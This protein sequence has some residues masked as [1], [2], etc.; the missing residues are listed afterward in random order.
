MN[1]KLAI[2]Y[3]LG[4]LA[5]GYAV[6]AGHSVGENTV[7]STMNV[8]VCVAGGVFLCPQHFFQNSKRC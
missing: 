7:A 6:Y 3:S 2:G 1:I 4:T 8:L 5:F